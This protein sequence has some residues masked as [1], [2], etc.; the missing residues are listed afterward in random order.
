[1]A[2]K[3]INVSILMDQIED[4]YLHTGKKGKY[5]NL[6]LR[7]TPDDPY[8]NNW[9]VVQGLP[10]NKRKEGDRG[11]ILGNGKNFVY[12][13]DDSSGS[14]EPRD[15]APSPAPTPSPIDDDVPF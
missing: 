1:M 9:M 3:I 12:D 15:K 10:K 5:L 4:K 14:P 11:R 13:D 6:V 2:N 7:E 8:K